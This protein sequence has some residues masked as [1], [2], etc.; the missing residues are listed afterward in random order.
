MDSILPSI[1]NNLQKELSSTQFELFRK[2][3]ADKIN[4]LLIND[5]A[6]LVQMLYRIDIDET[7]LKDSIQQRK[8]ESAGIVIAD[9]M[10]KRV[11]NS[12][13]T[14]KIFSNLSSNN[15]D[16]DLKW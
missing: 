11:S 12:I 13:E 2:E 1:Y 10:I 5:F 3:L 6:S 4:Y 8:T 16:E 15:I 9:M 14:K 7:K